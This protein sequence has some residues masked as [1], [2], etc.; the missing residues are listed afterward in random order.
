MVDEPVPVLRGVLECARSAT[1]YDV[2]DLGLTASPVH[3]LPAPNQAGD[4]RGQARAKRTAATGRA[5]HASGGVDY[6]LDSVA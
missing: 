4:A 2:G 5:S 1:G 6:V 3:A